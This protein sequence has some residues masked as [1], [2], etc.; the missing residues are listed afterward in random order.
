MRKQD[1]SVKKKVWLDV[2]NVNCYVSL[3][4]DFGASTKTEG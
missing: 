1:V 4:E 2:S 3:E